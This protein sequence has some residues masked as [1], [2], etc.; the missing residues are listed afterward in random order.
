MAEKYIKVRKPEEKLPENEI[1]IRG[2]AQVGAY[3]RRAYELFTAAENPQDTIVIKG[4]SAAM[5][6][7]VKLAELVKHRVKG[8]HQVTKIENIVF[9]DEYEP[10]EEGLD[11]LKFERNVTMLTVTLSKNKLDTSDVGY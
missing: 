10:I 9:I 7:V 1:R 8:I 6:S 2:G 3:L 4:M 5:E 11:T